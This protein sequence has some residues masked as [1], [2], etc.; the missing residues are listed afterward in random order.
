MVSLIYNVR[1][2]TIQLAV[3]R[4]GY[5]DAHDYGAGVGAPLS[6]FGRQQADEVA[7][8]LFGKYSGQVMPTVLTSEYLRARQ[9][10][11]PTAER[12]GVKLTVADWVY[13]GPA[14][15]DEL[16]A[17]LRPFD[18]PTVIV[19]GH[20]STIDQLYHL[21]GCRLPYGGSK[22]GQIVRFEL[23]LEARAVKLSP[24]EVT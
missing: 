20:A 15:L 5:Y 8:L 22:P 13:T 12:L 18:A 7:A 11:A 24:H 17:V 9:M 1:V 6:E 23:V 14:S 3:V 4:H 19:M 16:E 21:A 10:A 2:R